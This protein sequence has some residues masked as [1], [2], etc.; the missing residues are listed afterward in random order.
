MKFFKALL[1]LLLSVSAIL[2]AAGQRYTAKNSRNYEVITLGVG[3][4]GTKVVK[5]YVTEKNQSKAVALAKKAAVEVC[6]F[7]GLPSAGTVSGT[8]ALVSASAES[9]FAD[10]FERFFEPGGQYLRYVNITSEGAIPEEDVIKV[11]GGVKVG[12]I[13]QIM[14]DNLRKDLQ[15]DGI[16]K[17]LNYGF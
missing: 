10:Y 13:V 14:Y 12:V 7:R 9:E 17:P 6:I 2:P 3:T 8:P 16:V 11:K 15:N 5:I 1:I 4:D